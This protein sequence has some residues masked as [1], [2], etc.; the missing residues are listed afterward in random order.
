MRKILFISSIIYIF[1]TCTPY[2]SDKVNTELIQGKWQLM[3]TKNHKDKLDTVQIDY[4]EE[5]TYLIFKGNKCIQYMPDL[6]DTLDFTFS[7]YDYKL[8]L[9]K[10]S[11]YINK[12]NID[13]LSSD[14]L[15]LSQE[16][17]EHIYKK[18]KQY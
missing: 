5:F 13:S 6:A 8:T 9:Y 7:I 14:K 17:S 10:D 12:L 18:I 16:N 2:N 1:V 15:V 11:I 3:D 4:S